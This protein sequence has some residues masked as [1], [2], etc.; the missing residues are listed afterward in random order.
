MSEIN[1]GATVR[2][3]ATFKNADGQAADPTTVVFTSK[4]DTE[5]SLTYGVDAAVIKD[6]VGN[7]HIDYTVPA[8]TAHKQLIAY[9]W[10]GTGAVI[11]AGEG[12]FL[13]TTRFL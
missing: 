6:S 1:P 11:A 10:V 4:L 3:S 12:A 5:T 2:I 7:Y 9:R 13:V 8:I